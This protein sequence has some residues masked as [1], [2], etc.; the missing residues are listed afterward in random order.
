MIEMFPAMYMTHVYD[1]AMP[2]YYV[3]VA[4]PKTLMDAAI[5]A[6]S[7]EKGWSTDKEA[8]KAKYYVALKERLAYLREDI[9]EVEDTLVGFDSL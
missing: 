4:R 3:A 2:K 8:E 5:M 9:L 1:D 6:R 7:L